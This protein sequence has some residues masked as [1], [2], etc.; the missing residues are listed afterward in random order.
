MTTESKEIK[1]GDAMLITTK[2]GAKPF[3]A[4]VSK[5]TKRQFRLTSGEGEEYG[6]FKLESNSKW[7][8]KVQGSRITYFE[9]WDSRHSRFGNH[10]V[11]FESSLEY[12]EETHR[13]HAIADLEKKAEQD[14][15]RAKAERRHNEEMET[16]REA[17][18]GQSGLILRTRTQETMPDGSRLYTIDAPIN[19]RYEERKGSWERLIIRCKDIEEIDFNKMRKGASEEE[20]KFKMVESN[21]TY[22]NESSSSFASIS[23]SKHDDDA[24]AIWNSLHRQYFS[25]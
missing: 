19:P 8:N 22:C 10:E 2:W 17:C 16:V 9:L 7:N 12:L 5:V 23:T 4:S 24:A 15:H 6:P 21:Y 14:A 20:A 3:T 13:E 1:V 18:G 25:W 11:Y